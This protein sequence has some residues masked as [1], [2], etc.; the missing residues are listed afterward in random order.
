MAKKGQ[1]ATW[2]NDHFKGPKKPE[3]S[4]STRSKSCWKWKIKYILYKVN[5]NKKIS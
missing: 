2:E 1:E 5:I 4:K 3:S